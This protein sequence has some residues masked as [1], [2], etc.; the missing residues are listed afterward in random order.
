MKQFF[1]FFPIAMSLLTKI[2]SI[3]MKL[4]DY[5]SSDEKS[6]ETL[7]I[8]RQ[9]LLDALNLSQN[10]PTG[11]EKYAISQAD[12]PSLLKM[13]EAAIE[14]EVVRDGCSKQNGKF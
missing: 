7:S 6:D 11:I 2:R 8:L 14:E 3:K 1:F 4:M 10:P 12:P 9:H 5:R 13:V